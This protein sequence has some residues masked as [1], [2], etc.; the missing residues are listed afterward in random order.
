MCLNKYLELLTFK[1]LLGETIQKIW[2]KACI[3]F[4]SP[5][6]SENNKYLLVILKNLILIHSNCTPITFG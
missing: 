3:E 6:T 2:L 5:Q 4:S 1:N